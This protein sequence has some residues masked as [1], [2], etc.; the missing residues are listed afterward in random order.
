MFELFGDIALKRPLMM[1]DLTKREMRYLKKGQLQ[2]LPSRDRVG[3]RIFAFSGRPN[4]QYSA[5]ERY[6]T[7]LYLIGVCSEDATTQKL[8]LVSLQSPKVD[9]GNKPF[10]E[11][12]M[13]LGS[14]K[15]DAL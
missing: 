11:N 3:R 4:N 10:G 8:G 12:G 5:P 2:V 15:F 6:R 1:T 14:Q 7:L 13:A 9:P